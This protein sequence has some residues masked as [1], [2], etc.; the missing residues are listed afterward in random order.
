MALIRTL[1]ENVSSL[2]VHDT[3][4]MKHL[5]IRHPLLPLIANELGQVVEWDCGHCL[6]RGSKTH[7]LGAFF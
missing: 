2:L 4:N 7:F 6:S 5:Y 3:T 1:F